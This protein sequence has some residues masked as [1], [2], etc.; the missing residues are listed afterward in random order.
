MS[1]TCSEVSNISH[2]S[3][4]ATAPTARSWLIIEAPGAWGRNAVAQCDLPERLGEEL[5][6]RAMDTGTAVLVARRPGRTE[7]AATSR[8]VWLAHTAPG[9][10]SMRTGI[11]ENADDLLDIDLG[12]M[13]RGEGVAFGTRS[14]EP[15]VFICANS[16]RDACCA[17]QGGPLAREMAAGEFGQQ[18]WECSHLG[19]HRFAA[20]A[21]LLPWGTVHGRLAPA[22]VV[23]LFTAAKVGQ[24]PIG[25]YRGRS[26]LPRAFQAAEIA[27]RDKFDITGI[28]DLDVLRVTGDRAVPLAGG[29]TPTFDEALT[30]E[31]RSIDGRAWRV[32]VEPSAIAARIESCIGELVPGVD[33]K[34]E[35]I[36]PVNDWG[37]P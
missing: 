27:V 20:T 21:L 33:W 19:G 4:W 35:A 29:P 22:D 17:L 13:A 23:E 34:V 36:T 30:A 3:L 32:T 6:A 5:V 2:E 18:V 9:G 14:T 11:V 26:A 37:S 10:V 28:D 8:R 24:L 7:A 1:L 31:V 12:A 15:T 25:H 16:K